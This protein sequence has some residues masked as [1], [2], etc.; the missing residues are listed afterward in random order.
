MS[1]MSL[2]ML[3]SKHT[4][5]KPEFKRT[6]TSTE[7]NLPMLGKKRRR[8]CFFNVLQTAVKPSAFQMRDLNT[9][10]SVAAEEFSCLR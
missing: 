6:E 9:M 7:R 8:K 5:D 10:K 2:K 1:D 4:Q 3:H